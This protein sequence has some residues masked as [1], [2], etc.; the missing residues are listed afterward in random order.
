M[1]AVLSHVLACV[2]AAPKES[3]YE[4]DSD[5]ESLLEPPP[6]TAARPWPSPAAAATAVLDRLRQSHQ[7]DTSRT[8][9]HSTDDVC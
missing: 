8:P 3:A 6:K 4:P 5:L 1:R 7:T 2:G 9:A